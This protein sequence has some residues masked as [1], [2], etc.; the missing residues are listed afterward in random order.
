MEAELRGTPWPLTPL[1][2]FEGRAARLGIRVTVPPLAVLVAMKQSH[3]HFNVQANAPAA[4][5]SLPL[6][7]SLSLS[8]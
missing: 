2:G 7:S 3:L 4:V 5:L 1:A 8:P 6:P